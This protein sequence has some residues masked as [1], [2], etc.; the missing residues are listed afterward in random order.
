MKEFL[1]SSV[2]ELWIIVSIS[3]LVMYLI[4]QIRPYTELASTA[5]A[6]WVIALMILLSFPGSLLFL[7][8]CAV[9]IDINPS[10]HPLEVTWVWCELFAVGY[11][12]WFWLIPHVFSTSQPITLNLN[13][14][15]FT[16]SKLSGPQSYYSLQERQPSGSCEAMPARS[17]R[18]EVTP[19][20]KALLDEQCH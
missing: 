8:L 16:C 17:S 9:F 11:L 5:T 10:A 18:E 19:L 6:D 1:K 3:V 12:Q 15:E 20:E 4:G 14:G 2:K 7:A 13:S